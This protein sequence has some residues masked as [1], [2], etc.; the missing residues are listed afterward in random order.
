MWKGERGDGT[1][2]EGEEG[3]EVG[4]GGLWGGVRLLIFFLGHWY[5]GS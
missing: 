1:V 2:G 4:R 5:F 3:R